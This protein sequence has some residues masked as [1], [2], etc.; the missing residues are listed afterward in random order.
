MENTF[1]ISLFIIIL[2]NWIL[3]QVSGNPEG[4]GL[5]A[6]IPQGRTNKSSMRGPKELKRNNSTR[7][8]LLADMSGKD[9][10]L[11]NPPPRMNLDHTPMNMDIAE[12]ATTP[13][14]SA[15]LGGQGLGTFW[16]LHIVNAIVL[17]LKYGAFL[18][19]E[20]GKGAAPSPL[21]WPE[22]VLTST[23]GH[24]SSTQQP[25]S[26]A[27]NNNPGGPD[28]GSF[29]S[30]KRKHE[31]PSNAPRK[32]TNVETEEYR[33]YFHYSDKER[34]A[35]VQGEDVD[36]VRRHF[37]QAIDKL[38]G[39]LL[40]KMDGIRIKKGYGVINCEDAATKLW[41]EEIVNSMA[42]GAFRVCDKEEAQGRT[43]TV[44]VWVRV[45]HRPDPLMLFAAIS[46]HNGGFDTSKW[47]LLSSNKTKEGQYLLIGMDEES[48]TSL[49]KATLYHS[50]DRLKFSFTTNK[51]ATNSRK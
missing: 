31:S 5:R 7:Q 32:K 18:L 16:Q 33:V 20:S 15:A 11:R 14:G 28:S 10:V 47:R 29:G 34:G 30:N 44:G 37:C 2:E 25:S 39:S 12:G 22:T 4:A 24:R 23:G 51:V 3:I 9:K 26:S 50:I 45:E 21:K 6:T 19:S 8:F 42:Y 17:K 41:A 13:T 27:V 40:V 36:G 38:D 49:Q 1:L 46:T 48:Y 43:F 35:V